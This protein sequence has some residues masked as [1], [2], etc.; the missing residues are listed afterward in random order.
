MLDYLFLQSAHLFTLMAY[1]YG[2]WR[3]VPIRENGQ[4]L[5]AVPEE[6]SFPFYFEEMKLTDDKSIY[7]RQDVLERI[8][9]AR[10]LLNR[11]KF[12][13]KV[14]DGWRSIELQKKLFWYY[15]REFTAAIF[16]KGEEFG[17]LSSLEETE[18]FFNTLSPDIKSSMLEANKVYVSWPSKEPH[19]PSPHATGGSVDVWLF[20]NGQAADLG[21]PFDWMK[22]DA[23][24]FYHLK[25]PR[26]QFQKGDKVIRQ[27]R[28]ILLL[29]MLK[30]GFSCYEPEIWHFNYG[31]QMDALVK[32]GHAVYSYVEPA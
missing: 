20:K 1:K 24:A 29:A 15:M 4:S 11:S 10:S 3:K 16:G 27:N 14:Y 12:D 32:G 2:D 18:G 31:N 17:K 26:K 7:L 25:M 8:L 21:V 19:C 30:A 13:L 9:V 6:I 5:V 28:N 22:E 23:G